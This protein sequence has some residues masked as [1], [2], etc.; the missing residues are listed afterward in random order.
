MF[1]NTPI[2]TAYRDLLTGKASKYSQEMDNRLDLIVNSTTKKVV[3]PALKNQPET[4]F[5][6]IIMG[7]TTNIKDWKNEELSQYF[8]KEIVVQPTDSTFTE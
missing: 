5:K 7:L 3:V 4:I 8:A 2:Y 6:P 1:S